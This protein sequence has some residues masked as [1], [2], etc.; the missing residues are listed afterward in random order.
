MSIKLQLPK[1]VDVKPRLTVIGVGGAGCN[2]VNNMI[3]AGLQGV[4]FVVANTD[5]QSL[6]ASSAEHRVQLGTNLTEGLGAGS[7]PEIGEAAAEE[8]IEEIR[9]HI[10][11]AH[12]VF[13][14]AGMGGGT[15]TGAATVIA[16]AAR[17]T[18]ALTVG[19][20]CK[21]FQFEGARRMRI[22]EAG[23]QE[24]RQHVDTLI[25]IPNQNLFRI[26]NERT[27]FA[28]AFVL[29]DQVLYSGVACIVEL[30]LKEGLI[31]LD[32]AD[33]RTVMSGMG[34]A[35]MGTGEA[36]GERRAILAAEEAIANPLLDDVTLKGARGLLL[37][38]SGGRDMTLYEVDEAASRVRQEV[39]PEAN[40]IVGATFDEQLGDRIRVSIV[41]SGM[42]RAAEALRG[43]QGGQRPG[44]AMPG[45]P[46]GY[47]ANQSAPNPYAIQGQP[48]PRAPDAGPMQQPSGDV[49]R[50]LSDA[51]QPMSPNPL[52]NF[53]PSGAME[54]ARNRD[55]WIAP[56]KVMVEDGLENF[57]PL[58]GNALM[59]TP[60]LPQGGT[61]PPATHAFEPQ[62]PTEIQRTSRRLP[63]IEDFPPQ[64]Q[65]EW[66][67]HHGGYSAGGW[68]QGSEERRKQGFF[69][70]LTSFGRKAQEPKSSPYASNTSAPDS[71]DEDV[72]VPVFFSR[73][74]R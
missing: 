23:V 51:L 14:A 6:A 38:I 19:V 21:P 64:A 12:M 42:N 57:P 58:A 20:V 26:A 10:A 70:R 61:T 74:R 29:A 22:A 49:H 60:P 25:V 32:F 31:N 1:L 3:A 44:A 54:P 2:A 36:T 27:T 45:A 43:P 24:L 46:A 59:R 52:Q 18:G 47:S 53:S 11:G 48:S 17:E 35:M 62:P 28:E 8:A 9:T 69:G 63:A 7:R 16:R 55:T 65:R 37:S 71:D 39:D 56:G 73:E 50:R 72:Q 13:I 34:T 66:N 5:A 15:G 4:E 40:I 41:A 33:V 30:V 67:A 68:P